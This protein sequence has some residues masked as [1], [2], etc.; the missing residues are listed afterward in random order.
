MHHITTSHRQVKQVAVF[1]HR[2]ISLLTILALCLP[3]MP[4][5]AQ[6]TETATPD[7]S[8]TAAPTVT[9]TS[10][11]TTAELTATAGASETAVAT[12]TPSFTETAV[13]TEGPATAPTEVP[14]AIAT[15]APLI[16]SAQDS[17][18][19]FY[20]TASPGQVTPGNEV[21]FT[22]AITN[23]GSRP[24]TNIAFTNTLPEG[25]HGNKP[26]FGELSF[27]P[28]TRLL[29][30]SAK[31]LLPGATVTLQYTV[32]ASAK[33][34]PPLYLT[35]SALLTA[36]ELA[37]PVKGIATL[38]VTSPGEHLNGVAMTGDKAK[39]LG[40]KVEI[41]VPP[42][43]FGEGGRHAI[44]VKDVL[45]TYPAKE[46]DIWTA[47]EVQLLA[48]PAVVNA[49]NV[50]LEESAAEI[51][52]TD[53]HIN[54]QPVEAKFKRPVELA[55][56]FDGLADLSTLDSGYRPFMVTLDEA[57]GVWVEVPF[58]IDYGAN[59]IT[60]ETAHFST[61]GAGIGPSFPNNGANV[62]LFDSAKPDLFTGRSHFSIP[63]WTPPG[64]NGMAPSLSLSYSSGVAD[65]VLGDV[66]GSWV[67][68]GWSVDSIEISRKIT[69][70]GCSPCG[71]GSYGY[72]DE[73]ILTFN[74]LGGELI[75][76][77]NTPGR[78]H[79][80]DES[81]LYIQRHNDNLLPAST[82]NTTGEWWEVVTK[83]GTHWRLGYNTNS[84]Q[85]AAMKGYPGNNTGAWSSLGYAG[86]TV[87]RVVG[88]WRADQV[89]DTH[90]N[91]MT[92][93]YFE[94]T[95]QFTVYTWTVGTGYAWGP[96]QVQAGPSVPSCNPLPS[97]PQPGDICG[98][99]PVYYTLAECNQL[100]QTPC[101][102]GQRYDSY[103]GGYWAPSPPLPTT[104]PAIW[105][106]WSTPSTGLR[107]LTRLPLCARAR[108]VRMCLR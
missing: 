97:N 77:P 20:F 106:K 16:P 42:G 17:S 30:W 91:Q 101:Q 14:P 67:G 96:A 34:Q 57:S 40:N 65:G 53:E 103:V 28:N 11:V 72:R 8:A 9:A 105:I 43:A 86:H 90:G 104:G 4:V 69:N 92:F 27:D 70:G 62:L 24:L 6:A 68:L 51:A 49:K 100:G 83:D 7:S 37:E 95:G 73:Y 13:A 71:S 1:I 55:V 19:Q 12:G 58:T 47:F 18:L 3:P 107:R 54:L 36:A 82:N 32:T 39:G 23:A 61:W 79:T 31:E 98:D 64:R 45:A 80:K 78:Y 74:G 88:R 22:I 44:L 50:A 84:E 41:D 21:T 5:A 87:D 66:Q 35:D 46:G 102:M 81:F 33:G 38:L 29:T 26:G 48:D 15:P 63:I 10:E 52:E 25:L 56:S 94:E 59:T 99:P 75:A 93:T 76:D 85:L 89:T 2:F 108:A 60:T